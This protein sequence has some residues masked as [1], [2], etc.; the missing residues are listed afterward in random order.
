MRALKVRIGNSGFG[1]NQGSEEAPMSNLTATVQELYAAF[2]R[3]DLPAILSKLADDV[4]WE[5]EAPAVIK[6]SGMRHGVT[7]TRG[8]FEAIA[9][10][11]SDPKLTITEY[12]ESGDTVMTIGRYT[13]TAKPS[14]RKFDTPIAITGSFVMAKS[15]AI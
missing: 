9:A 14:G 5:Y 1:E 7:E 6:L 11:N 13:A 10:E 4:V 12:V 15:S 8:F 2:G 3:G